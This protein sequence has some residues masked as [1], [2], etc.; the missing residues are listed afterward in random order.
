MIELQHEFTNW[1]WMKTKMTDEMLRNILTMHFTFGV[2]SNNKE[3]AFCD[4]ESA[5]FVG[6]NYDLSASSSFCDDCIF[7]NICK[8]KDRRRSKL[9]D[10]KLY[11]I[12]GK[13]L[14]E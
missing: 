8:R 14:E 13:H 3:L 7:A 9:A 4:N 6:E 10:A 12:I 1:D 11:W 2:S 5:I